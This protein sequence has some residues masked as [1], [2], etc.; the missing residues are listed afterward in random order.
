MNSDS[1]QQLFQRCGHDVLARRRDDHLL[2]A[3]HDVEESV[4]VA[5]TQIAGVQPPSA[6]Q[7]VS[8]GVDLPV[9]ARRHRRPLEQ[10]LAVVGDVDADSGQR[11][12]D[13]AEAVGRLGVGGRRAGGLGHSV[14]VVDA[15]PPPRKEIQR[16]FG[17]GR[18]GGGGPRQSVQ[19]RT[20]P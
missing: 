9:I 16:L 13:A 2:L 6:A 10:D 17:H 18:G 15:D 19:T 1:Q 12:P 4:G 14:R 5:A 11:Q 20:R 3:T 7:R 8:T